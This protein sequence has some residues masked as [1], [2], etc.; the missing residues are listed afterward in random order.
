MRSLRADAVQQAV[1]FV[2]TMLTLRLLPHSARLR[3]GAGRPAW[4]A[5]VRRR[6][7]GG[8]GSYRQPSSRFSLASD[9]M[10][11]PLHGTPALHFFLFLYHAPFFSSLPAHYDFR[12]VGRVLGRVGAVT[13]NTPLRRAGRG[14]PS[15]RCFSVWFSRSGCFDVSTASAR[16]CARAG[17][18]RPKS[19]RRRRQRRW[20]PQA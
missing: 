13:C 14:K 17:R 10:P 3:A 15:W 1:S 4:A 9:V 20:R 5:A 16:H 11:P 12:A 2:L 8:G 18:L 19:A 6:G 7:G